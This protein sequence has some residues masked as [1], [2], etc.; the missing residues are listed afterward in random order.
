MPPSSTPTGS[1]SPAQPWS[2]GRC[3]LRRPDGRLPAGRGIVGRRRCAGRGAGPGR[4]ALRPGHRPADPPDVPADRGRPQR[5]PIPVHHPVA[6][7]PRH[8]PVRGRALLRRRPRRP[9]VPRPGPGRRPGGGRRRPAHGSWHAPSPTRGRTGRRARRV[10]AGIGA[11]RAAPVRRSVAGASVRGP[12]CSG[13]VHRTRGPRLPR[14]VRGGRVRRRL[15]RATRRTR[16]GPA[17]AQRA[18]GRGV[19][20]GGFP[21]RSPETPREARYA[22]GGRRLPER[23]AGTDS[24]QAGDGTWSRSSCRRRDRCHG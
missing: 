5:R 22:S 23:I 24:A 11:A 19:G 2:S 1:R 16:P 6:H 20:P 9:A 7:C 17:S 4:T 21:P 12:G 14:T 8:R 3:R 10:P 15:A 13:T 18:G